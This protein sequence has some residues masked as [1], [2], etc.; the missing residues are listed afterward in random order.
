[1]AAAI[2]PDRER[3]TRAR[4]IA[5]RSSM[6]TG[7]EERRIIIVRHAQSAANAGGRTVDPASIP[8][9]ATGVLQAQ[10]VADLV[11][12]RPSLIAVSGFLRT[13]QTAG[14]LIRTYPGVPV[15]Q[16]P[17]EEFTYL[18]PATCAGTT[19]TERKARRDSYWSR[20]DPLWV[21][22]PGCE[23]FAEFVARVR[24]FHG[25]LSIR[26]ADGTVVVFTHGLV[27]QS[28]LWLEQHAPD[29]ITSE[30][31]ADFDTFR[32]TI[33]VPNCAVLQASADESGTLRFSASFSLAHLSLDATAGRADGEA[34]PQASATNPHGDLN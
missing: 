1:M 29:E 21:D 31:M 19:Y 6:L 13:A 23:S 8:I 33:A 16:W 24:Q 20:S 4:L 14:P 12:V 25:T 5:M 32:R 26:G 11:G 7:R 15:E 28:L 34:S 27:M 30:V 3:V 18:D 9:T 22:G 10:R 2:R 17:I